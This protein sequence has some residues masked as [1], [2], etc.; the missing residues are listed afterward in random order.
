[1]AMRMTHG[2]RNDEM[3][4]GYVFRRYE[5]NAHYALPYEITGYDVERR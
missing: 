4:I 5:N 2:L 3:R 1:M